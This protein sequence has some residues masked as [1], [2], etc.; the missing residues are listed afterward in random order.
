MAIYHLHT[1][2]VGRS[3]GRS[4][5]G[6]AAYRAGEKIVDAR[7]G[8]IFDFSRRKNVAFRAIAAPRD[9]KEWVCDRE[10]LWNAA[11]R[12]ERRCDAQVAREIEVSL[13]IEL[14]GVA[15]FRLIVEFVEAEFVSRGMVA[16]IAIHSNEGNPHAHILLTLRELLP[17]GFG[18]KVRA[19]NDRDLLV[20]WRESWA[21]FCNAA[22]KSAGIEERVD[23]RSLAAQG[24]DR[25][26]KHCIRSTRER[27]LRK[28]HARQK[29]NMRANTK[30]DAMRVNK[31]SGSAVPF[32]SSQ[33]AFMA[34]VKS[35]LAA[36]NASAMATDTGW[37]CEPRP[38]DGNGLND[39][40]NPQKRR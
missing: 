12:S 28:L 24:I 6:A 10:K 18:A 13:P 21:K 37:E 8:R 26:P 15:Q 17:E 40:E 14:G 39:P 22:L 9:A 16:D 20:A 31:P 35:R 29:G 3:G 27:L 23:H 30:N 1:K 38:E 7:T 33:P 2:I 34:R 4:A 11:E 25:P 19:W 36:K 5:T 32:V